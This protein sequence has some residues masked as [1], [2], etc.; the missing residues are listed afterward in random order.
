MDILGP[1]EKLNNLLLNGDFLC[2]T[3]VENVAEM[4]QEDRKIVETQ[5]SKRYDDP[6]GYFRS[7][8]RFS[9]VVDFMENMAEF[10]PSIARFVPSIGKSVEGRDIP[11]IHIR[12]AKTE[13]N[14]LKTIWF[15]GG[16]HARE[17]ISV[18]VVQY[19]IYKLIT[20]Y[21]KDE[22]VTQLLNQ[23]EFVIAP[24]I[25]PD[26]YEFSWT[27]Q[28][29]WRKNRRPN[30]SAC[31]GVDL[32]RNFNNHWGGVGASAHPCA[33]D[34]RGPSVASEPETQAVQ[35]YVLSL[36][37]RSGGI[38]F[39]S[40]GQLILRSYGYA[41]NLSPNE[42]ILRAVGD[43][44]RQIILKKSGMRYESTRAAEL[45]PTTGSTDDWYTEQAGMWGWTIELR[46]VGIYGFQ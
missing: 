25:N 3:T 21:G 35:N 20:E 40:Y 23:I 10:N 28:R 11:V 18:A 33:E 27:T 6:E 38:D 32:N 36:P 42:N 46:D 22:Q 12:G 43:G 45:Y 26:G 7:Y 9:E 15:S 34:Y 41:N 17:W 13:A 31:A 16:I 44:M 14:K 5:R 4:I 37:N 39:H 24:C 2:N 29:M 19:L 8:H 30:P 1:K